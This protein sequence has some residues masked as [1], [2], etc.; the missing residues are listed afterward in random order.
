ML[1]DSLFPFIEYRKELVIGALHMFG[2]HPHFAQ[3]GHKMRIPNPSRDDME[4]EMF[5]NPRA[6]DL[7]YVHADIK[8]LRPEGFL[9]TLHRPLRHFHEVKG[10]FIGKFGDGVD[11]PVRDHH[12]VAVVVGIEVH[13]HKAHGAPVKDE[14]VPVRILDLLFAKDTSRSLF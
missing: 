4:V 6:G 1:S 7:S 13:H 14:V 8:T 5:L 3:Y 9:E 10:F 11:M 2:D 12:E